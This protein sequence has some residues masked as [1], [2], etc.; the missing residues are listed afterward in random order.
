[1]LTDT[2]T[3][4]TPDDTITEDLDAALSA[5]ERA[6]AELRAK[7]ALAKGSRNVTAQADAAVELTLA[8]RITQLLQRRVMSPD[9]LASEL[10]AQP[11]QLTIA[12]RTIRKRL[13]NVGGE[14]PRWFC[15]LG[16]DATTEAINAAVEALIAERPM[17]SA[18]LVAATGARG[19]RVSGAIVKLQRDASRSIINLGDANR[20]RWF[21]V[22]PSARSAALKPR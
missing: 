11:E 18:E 2:D 3:K 19:S 1:M 22:P 21:L 5:A 4:P 6:L 10:G 14:T 20:G 9:E 15:E 13:H 12:L 16:D 7:V 17:T 8:E